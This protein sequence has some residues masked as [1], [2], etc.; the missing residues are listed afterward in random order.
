MTLNHEE[1]VKCIHDF[2]VGLNEAD[3]LRL[4]AI[5]DSDQSGTVSY[6][7][8]LRGVVGEMNKFRA[9]I[10]MKAFAIMDKDGSG[11]IDLDD[12]KGVYNATKHPDVISG[13]K[14]E[15]EVLYEFLDTFEVHHATANGDSGKDA[16]DGSVTKPE[17]K[18]YYNNI[19]CSIERDDYFELMMNNAWNLKGDRVTKKGW[20][21]AY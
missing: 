16:R 7:E 1:F 8:F 13:K 19:S 18:E 3:S 6:D 4:F 14:T 17:W 11:T 15:D 12:I 2:R 9:N 20:G 21:G 5:Y 10:A